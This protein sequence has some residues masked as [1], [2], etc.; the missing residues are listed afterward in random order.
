MCHIGNFQRCAQCIAAIFDAQA[1]QRKKEGGV[2][3]K[4]FSLYYLEG[5]DVIVVAGNK[6]SS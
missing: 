3:G 4:G 5:T 2:E 1:H 6:F